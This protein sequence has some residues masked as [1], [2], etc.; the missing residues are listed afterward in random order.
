MMIENLCR[1]LATP[2]QSDLVLNEGELHLWRAGLD[3]TDE[4]LAPLVRVLSPDEL[5]RA[6]RFHF[7]R[8][9]RRFMAARGVLR[10]VIA[11]YLRRPAHEISFV[12]GSR[13]KP[14]LANGDLQFNLAHSGGLAIIGLTRSGQLG[15]DVERI[16]PLE[17][18]MQLVNSFFSPLECQELTALPPEAQ[19]SAFFA[20]WT[21]KEAYVKAMGDG[22]AMPLDQ[23]DMPVVSSE[24]PRLLHVDVMSN[25][26]TSWSLWDVPLEAGYV[27][28]VA[29]AGQMELLRHG[30]WRRD[31]PGLV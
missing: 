15:V 9:R 22:L 4:E 8:D 5:D 29:F 28:S 7:T 26:T 2:S 18:M 1:V 30:E 27:G 11:G 24:P 25:E 3:L 31:E 19:Q 17:D 10:S 14:A 16:R 23:F 6:T 12:Y 20:C 13:G 21:R